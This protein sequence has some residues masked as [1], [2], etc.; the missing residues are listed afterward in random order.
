MSLRPGGAVG[1]TSAGLSV[2]PGLGG[3]LHRALDGAVKL[4]FTQVVKF[5]AHIDATT[6]RALAKAVGSTTEPV[7]TGRAWDSEF[8][9]M[10][11]IGATVVAPLLCVAAM[12]AVARQDPGMLLRSAFMRV[13][14]ALL[15]T[16]VVVE[17]VS[18]GMQATDQACA[19]LL[20][21]AGSPLDSLFARILNF[22]GPNSAASLSL[23]F[24]CVI[25]LGIVSFA[26]WLELAV[27]S[28]AIGVA[29]LFLPLA[30]AGLALPATAHWA[31]RLAETLVALVLSKLAIVAVLTL[32]VGTL[33]DM[34]GGISSAVEGM[35]L[36]GL[37]AVAPLALARLLP[38]VEAGAVAHLDGLGH[39]VAG[40]AADA[41]KAS[42]SWINSAETGATTLQGA[43]AATGTQPG[44]GG[45]A[46]APGGGGAGVAQFGERRPPA[47]EEVPAPSPAGP[48]TVDG[49]AEVS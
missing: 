14:L 13:P 29:T 32:A 12:Q 26:V 23:N 36:F 19:A 2:V 49:P 18:L 4:W 42:Y 20:A 37:A 10:A 35:T 3:L 15:L 45:G 38:M 17:L 7:L 46:G 9:T 34:S 5:A 48:A 1:G 40:S 22:L 41:A 28:A 21:Q 25:F 24:L 39:R 31:R 11:V 8:K 30:L 6:V 33:F 43:G 44:T 16:A 47:G 27:R